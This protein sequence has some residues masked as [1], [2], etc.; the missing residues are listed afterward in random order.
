MPLFNFSRLNRKILVSFISVA[1]IMF[2][3]VS[4]LTIWR[5]S[6]NMYATADFKAVKEAHEDESVISFN[7]W[8]LDHEAL[9]ASLKGITLS[10]TI[11]H[12]EVIENGEVIAEQLRGGKK[13]A[14]DRTFSIDLKSPDS[15]KKIGSLRVTQSYDDLR[16]AIINTALTTAATE[17]VK[18]GVLAAILL[19]IVHHLLIRRLEAIVNDIESVDSTPSTAPAIRPR[20]VDGKDELD[21]LVDSLNRYRNDRKKA[22]ELLRADIAERI[23]VESALQKSEATLSDALKIARIGYWEYEPVSQQFTLNDQYFALH[24]TAVDKF[25]GYQLQLVEFA[26]RMINDNDAASVVDA[27]QAACMNSDPKSLSQIEARIQCGDQQTR[28]VMIRFKAERDQH[29]QTIKLIGAAQDITDR[30][31]AEQQVLLLARLRVQKEAAEIANKAK[32]RFFATASHDLRQPIHALHL[33][34][35]TLKNMSLPPEAQR[36]LTNVLRCT[37]SIDEMFVSLLDVAKFDAGM[38]SPQISDFPVMNILS[39]IRHE[40]TPQASSKGLELSVVPCSIW[41][42]S[43]PLM[44]ERIVRN[45]VTNAIR[46]TTN[47]KILVGCRRRQ[48]GALE[49]VVQDTGIGIAPDQQ[50]KIF[51]EFYKAAPGQLNQAGLGLG[52]S[53]VDQLARMLTAPVKLTSVENKGSR[54]SVTLP[55]SNVAD[56]QNL[57]MPV[58]PHQTNIAGCLIL[59]VDDDEMI[60]DAARGLLEQWGCRV[61]TAI[62]IKTAM[63]LLMDAPE[64]PHA[65]ICDYRLRGTETGVDAVTMIC[66]EFNVDIPALLLTGDTSPNRILELRDTGLPVLHKPIRDHELRRA[67]SMLLQHNRDQAHPVLIRTGTA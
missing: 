64:L 51:V 60:L 12:A 5:E 47:G 50:D 57:S 59:L 45:L 63:Q 27:I 29:G 26:R 46:Y 23:R 9:M 62:D 35:G 38:I 32:S 31:V 11:V 25:D 7:L 13:H 33:F 14:F 39:R 19:I 3:L 30:K 67:L 37:E 36:P 58:M 18:I 61:M 54:F 43:D 55:I 66:E 40:C 52:L 56:I 10:G 22:E 49:L 20:A 24:E 34:L 4:A 41:I 2:S 48:G 1:V 44:V 6:D 42:N 65:M 21:T 16:A 53:I 8:E 28:W 17:L 15:L